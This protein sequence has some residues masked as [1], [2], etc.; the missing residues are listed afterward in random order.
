LADD[1]R[2]MIED[3]RER[4]V[5]SDRDA[6][7][8][9]EAVAAPGAGDGASRGR[10]GDMQEELRVERLEGDRVRIG[11]WILRPGAG[12]ELQ[13]APVMMPAGRYA[14]ALRGAELVS[15]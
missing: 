3:V 1:L 12:W 2:T 15:S 4:S 14:E 8:L 10:S 9:A 6:E 11:R 13:E 7:A 5:L